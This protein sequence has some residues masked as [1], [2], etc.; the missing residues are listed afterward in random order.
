MYLFQNHMWHSQN[1]SLLND[2][3]IR[4]QGSIDLN[5]GET[6]TETFGVQR[7]F[8]NDTK[9]IHILGSVSTIKNNAQLSAQE[10]YVHELLHAVR[11]V[12]LANGFF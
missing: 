7:T 6:D 12:L 1:D 11:L 9:D 5:V 2:N 8:D 3:L 4:L 10:V